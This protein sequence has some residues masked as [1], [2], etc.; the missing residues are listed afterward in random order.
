MQKL[1]LVNGLSRLHRISGRLARFNLKRLKQGLFQVETRA[2]YL[3]ASF[4]LALPLF[5]TANSVA[6]NFQHFEQCSHVFRHKLHEAIQQL[7]CPR[8]SCASNTVKRTK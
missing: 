2:F 7:P 3:K 6:H 8:P 4:L 1:L 5:H